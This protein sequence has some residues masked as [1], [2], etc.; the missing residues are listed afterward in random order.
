MQRKI[1]A[2]LLAV[3][4][5]FSIVA[6]AACNSQT[7]TTTE[8]ETVS[9]TTTT[10]SSAVTSEAPFTGTVVNPFENEVSAG[11]PKKEHQTLT[12]IPSYYTLVGSTT[13]PPV[14]NQGAVGSCA[15]ESVAYMQFTNAVAQ[16]VQ[17]VLG[18]KNWTPS[19]GSITDTTNPNNKYIFSPKF[20]YLFSSAGTAWV[21]NILMDHGCATIDYSMFHKNGT[22]SVIQ[23]GTGFYKES[24]KWDVQEGELL[25]ALQFRVTNYE[26]IWCTQEPYAGKLTTSEAGLKLINKIKEAVASGNVV[27]TGGYPSRW[28][29]SSVI[30][31]GNLGKLGDKIISYS[32][33]EGDGGHQVCIVGYDDDITAK[34]GSQILKGA[35]LMV[36][37]WGE[38]Y[39][40]KGYIWVSYDALN[41]VSEY[42]EL[43]DEKYKRGWT[44]DQFCFTYWDC[45]IT[46]GLPEIMAEVEI[47]ADDRENFYMVL[48]REDASGVVETHMP[49]LFYYGAGNSKIHDN[50]GVTNFGGDVNTGTKDTGYFTLSY[51]RLTSLIPSN[52]TVNDYIWGVKVYTLDTKKTVT[53]KSLK[54]LNSKQEVLSEVKPTGSMSVLEGG[55]DVYY[56]FKLTEQTANYTVNGQFLLLNGSEYLVDNRNH[57]VTGNSIDK[58]LKLSIVYDIESNTYAIKKSSTESYVLDISG[59]EIAS[60]VEVRLNAKSDTRPNQVWKLYDYGDGTFAI[61][62][63]NTDNNGVWYA[64]GLKDGKTVLVTG[65]EIEKYGKWK[66]VNT[67]TEKITVDLTS[68]DGEYK[69]TVNNNYVNADITSIEVLNQSG[70]SVKAG[71][72]SGKEAE[73]GKLTAGTY[74]VVVDHPT[75]SLVYYFVVE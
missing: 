14:E 40:N 15:S 57:F 5:C 29:T 10:P 12:E 68:S 47:E 3:L 56:K 39:G 41:T 26:Q 31:K 27:V 8:T 49:Y 37:S 24:L 48:T 35:F 61:Y 9:P 71:I 46:S 73:L 38:S 45:D 53:V 7:P 62:L 75:M 59:K 6:L 2:L 67:T 64:V 16:Y 51:E 54:L 52:K 21:Y 44:F 60:D 55:K 69:L 32:L 1:L 43:N 72:E 25:K 65:D 66:A 18:D 33:A 19:K 11:K 50:Y 23:S 74:S 13:L 34:V 4:T 17:N 22:G 70:E 42:E 63:A 20:T 58:A 28:Q 30:D 36:N